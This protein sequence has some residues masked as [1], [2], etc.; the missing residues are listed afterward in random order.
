MLK[1]I[2]EMIQLKK[3][4]HISTVSIEH[5]SYVVDVSDPQTVVPGQPKLSALVPGVGNTD[6]EQENLGDLETAFGH[7]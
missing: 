1:T 7:R 5:F 3:E 6:R 4:I 2:I